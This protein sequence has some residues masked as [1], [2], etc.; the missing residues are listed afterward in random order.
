MGKKMHS[1]YSYCIGPYA[2]EREHK[3]QFRHLPNSRDITNDSSTDIFVRE[4]DTEMRMCS[5]NIPERK[6]AAL[7][8]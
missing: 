1:R 2:M 5:N 8:S 4:R 3:L 6:M 7:G